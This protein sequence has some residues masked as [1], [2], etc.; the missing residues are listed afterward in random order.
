MGFGFAGVFLWHVWFLSLVAFFRMHAGLG[1]G[2]Q[3]VLFGTV[4]EAPPDVD[5]VSG[6]KPSAT[7]IR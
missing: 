3:V 4:A 7:A 6:F 2:S 5:A 1:V